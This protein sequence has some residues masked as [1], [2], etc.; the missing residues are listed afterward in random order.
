MKNI[1]VKRISSVIIATFLLFSCAT[2]VVTSAATTDE[3]HKVSLENYE[4]SSY[5]DAL[6]DAYEEY[7]YHAYLQ[8]KLVS[9]SL[10]EFV[11]G[12]SDKKSIDDYRLEMET[13]LQNNLSL[14]EIQEQS[15]QIDERAVQDLT[16]IQNA[17]Y[18]EQDLVKPL[19]DTPWYYNC[20]ELSHPNAYGRYPKLLDDTIASGDV[21]IDQRGL[22]GITGHIAV[23]VG[24]YYS[25]AFKT[26][27]VRVV[28]AVA[29]GVSYGILCDQRVDD[30]VSYVYR[31]STD[32]AKR[33][34]AVSWANSQIGKPYR[35]VFSDYSKQNVKSSRADWY[36]SLLC[37][38]A[39]KAQG[40][41]IGTAN[42]PTVL[43]PRKLILSP[44]MYEKDIR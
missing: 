26:Y 6:K 25:Y 14:D 20:P 10:E 33:L 7:S 30:R 42:G 44:Y 15:K 17:Q 4:S 2:S 40:V 43:Y 16:E 5:F 28:E 18:E 27:Y 34:A 31:V 32:A 29:G 19:G 11:S 1:T 13:K 36:C 37:Y 39:Y 22:F 12:Y 8:K 35:L 41:D 3:G 24:H 38:A 23:V 9:V 21:I